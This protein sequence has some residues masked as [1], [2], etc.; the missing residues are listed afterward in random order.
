MALQSGKLKH[1]PS[2]PEGPDAFLD[3]KVE[4]LFQ[5]LPA[6]ILDICY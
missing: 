6:M 1:P 3:S 2:P 4:D 5:R